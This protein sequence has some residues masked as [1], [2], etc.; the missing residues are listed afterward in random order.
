MLGR[1][2]KS[3][4]LLVFLV[5]PC[6]A[7][8]Q[9]DQAAAPAPAVATNAPNTAASASKKVWTNDDI[10]STK[11]AADRR[12][13]NNSRMQTVPNVDGATVDRIRKGLEK[14]QSQI[15][16][17]D[18]KLKTYKDF[19][20]GEPVSTGARDLTKGINRTPVE[21]QVGQLQEKKKELQAQMN[22]LLDE[23]RKKGIDP[24]LLR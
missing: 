7:Q 1:L 2:F 18:K 4:C 6:W 8:S 22:D 14:L 12:N 15:D 11:P 19:Q 16:D 21:Q 20:E 9:N 3:S 13:P 17:I 23:A 10:P 24:G 5:F